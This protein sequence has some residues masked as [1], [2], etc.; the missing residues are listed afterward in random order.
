MSFNSSRSANSGGNLKRSND[1]NSNN[2][3][4]NKK[5][6]KSNQK[7][8]GMAWGSNSLSSSKSSSR[9]SNFTDFGSYMVVKN[10]KLH[11]QFNAEATSSSLKDS[12]NSGN[13][14]LFHGVSIF[15][16]GFTVPSSQELR[17]YMLKYGGRFE[18][19]FSRSRVTHIICSNLPDSKVKN[20]RSFSRG[21]PVVK[22]TWVLDSVAANKL[23]NWVPYQL[24][25]LVNDVHKQPKLSAFF[26]PKTSLGLQDAKT[27][28][29]CK[30]NLEEGCSLKDANSQESPSCEVG[31]ST[32]Y[33]PELKEE[34]CIY[35]QEKV[36][37]VTEEEPISA[38]QLLLES[39]MAEPSGSNFN[40]GEAFKS[41]PCKSSASANDFIGD[42]SKKSP[43]SPQIATSSNQCNS[44]LGDPNFVENYFKNSRLHFIG[45][46]RNRYRKRFPS[47]PSG[48]KDG[49]SAVT[50]GASVIHIDMDCFF[51]SVIIRSRPE[52]QDKPVA[53]CHSDN[54]R[55]TAEISSANYPA[56]D[57]GVRAG[58]FV[59]DA[60]SLCP[61]LVIV[62]YNFEAYELVADQFYQILHKHCNKVQ[63]VSC[64]EAFLDVSD[65]GLEEAEHIASVIRQEIYEATG[66]TASAG[67]AGNVLMARLATRTAKP[68]GQFLIPPEKVEGFLD[69]LPIKTLPGIGHVLDDKLKRL[70]IQTCGQLRMI[71]KESLQKDFGSKTGNMLWNYSRGIDSRPVG[72]VQ[73]TKSVGAE[74]N[75]GVRF[76]TLQ[77]SQNFLVK[78]CHEVS[79]RLQGCGVQGRTITL[80][81]K[82]KRKDAGEPTKYMG[83]GDCE[84]LSHAMTIPIA[85]NDVDVLQ[86]ISKQLFG[87]FHLDVKEI[88]GIGLQVSRLENA[89]MTSQGH[90]RSSL[91]SWLSSASGNMEERSHPSMEM[92]GEVPSLDGQCSAG[93]TKHGN[94]NS[95]G[96]S[97]RLPKSSTGPSTWGHTNQS[98]AEASLSRA[99]TLP[100]ICDLDM[101]VI[102]SLP[103][104]IFSEINDLYGGKLSEF[105][106]KNDGKDDKI[107]D[108]VISSSRRELEGEIIKGKAP[109]P[110]EEIHVEE[111]TSKNKGKQ[112]RFQDYQSASTSAVGSLNLHTDPLSGDKY[113]LMPTSLSQVDISI[114]Q[115][116]PKELKVDILE[117]LPAHRRSE[118]SDSTLEKCPH[119]ELKVENFKDQLEGAE[120]IFGKSLW[121]GCPPEWVD[122]FEVSNNMML[123][124][125]AEMY[126]KSGSTG[127][128][129]S[130]LQSLISVL[131]LSLDA[132]N[133]VD[134]NVISSLC[135]ILR[136]YIDLKIKSDMEEIYICF[137]L[138]RRFTTKSIF[139]L[140]AYD[141]VLPY[142]QA[143]F[144]ENYGGNLNI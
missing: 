117:S 24:E 77:D 73:E 121:S 123:K 76:N 66:C 103:P 16:D 12:S 72:V 119:D 1:S 79:L 56:R 8:L 70:R 96:D 88:R 17:S 91:R 65:Q 85:T 106:K 86:R 125:I 34:T 83:Y 54:P 108:S 27:A 4:N 140:E 75:W 74:V 116:L 40:G 62:P 133:D 82:K 142:L 69:E 53:V 33:S 129:S 46:W 81:L 112:C 58:I 89:D 21:L 111:T 130:I 136:Q 55:G 63:A 122:K 51:V 29:N 61:H 52:L 11:D 57:F 124:L 126:Y 60:K 2:I 131:P 35:G 23:L 71:T 7:T 114:L 109:L 110:S 128:L 118:C 22:P 15:V 18:N 26:A 132:S 143:S 30:L 64:D 120:S 68:N 39:L 48:V 80:K 50:N 141:R 95:D 25:Q 28:A 37:E 102:E 13:K 31:E 90:E 49:N 6:K 5:L 45:T 97:S 44:T 105:L 67:V 19:Y 87:Y 113:E 144:S 115:Q 94:P 98:P 127:F 9:K 10:G 42:Q 32:E 84:N 137:L 139:F 93:L 135:D 14:P 101:G 134:D 92:T 104:E 100:Q 107:S 99:S 78:L 43:S 20:I 41:S 47:L 3:N 38:E 138:L 59:R 36:F